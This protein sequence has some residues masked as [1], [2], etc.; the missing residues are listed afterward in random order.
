MAD[1]ELRGV[2]KAYGAIEVIKGVDLSIKHG[3]FCVFVGPS[4]CGKST[5]LRMISGLESISDGEVLIEGEVV[6]K[7]AP[8]DRGLAMVFQSYA[9][10][11]H[12]TVRQNLTFG[13]ENLNTP[14]SE[15]AAKVENVAKML[16]I[17]PLLAR[18]PKDLSGGQRQRVAI[19][20]A[21][22]REPRVFLFDEPLSNLD[23]ELRVEMRGEIS[24]LHRRLG[25]T[26]IYVTH[27]QVEAMTMA[28]KIAV[29][30]DG[31]V[32]QYGA[33]LD[34]Y[35]AP[36][37]LFVAGFIGSPRMN[38][39]AGR[40]EGGA[41]V[42]ASGPRVDLPANR[43]ALRQGAEV[44]IGI[45]PNGLQLADTG[46]ALS[47]TGVERTRWRKLPL[48]H[49]EGRRCSDRPCNRANPDRNGCRSAPLNQQQR[50]T[51]VRNRHDAQPAHGGLGMRQTWR[52]FGPKDTVRVEEMLQA[53]VE[54]VVSALHH[55]PPGQEWTLAEIRTRQAEI[56]RRSDGSPSG[57]SWE[58]VE[59]VP[60][61]EVIKTKGPGY[62]DHI[63]AYRASIRNLAACGISVLCYNFMPVLDWTRTV[64]RWPLPNGGTAMMFDLVDFA[65]FDLFI[66]RRAGAAADYGD[67]LTETATARF[68]G[69]SDA[70][71]QQLQQNVVA[72]LPGANDSW[73]VE[74]I[75]EML[76]I[77]APISRDQLAANLIDFLAEVVPTA[78]EVGMRLCCHPDDPP[79]PLLGLP[80][81]MSS[82]ADYAKVL[83]A[84]DSPAS[85]VTFCTGS[86]GV[87]AGFDAVGFVERLGAHIHFVHLRNTRRIAPASGAR[88]SFHE[89]EHLAGDTDIVGVIRV[90]LAEERKR[91]AAGR[92]DWQLPFRPD[93]GQD[94]MDD[95]KRASMPG[96]PLIGRMR[97]LA[98][99]RGVIAAFERADASH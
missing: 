53:G 72:G 86:L 46:L 92:V 21:V 58:V 89:S 83:A 51:C 2:T 76:A 14:K 91:K 79:F 13:L 11:P 74:Q 33:P 17:E 69:M 20:R 98:E 37:N 73:T 42:L 25:N 85:G 68:S 10:Y 4:G 63:A 36:D 3:E 8:A 50:G 15:I 23:A 75:R 60:V 95:L 93:H 70:T 24:R 19:G 59:S 6:N 44:T 62:A 41:V 77:Y 35:N 7:L 5:L 40:V 29:L 87:A 43:F 61:S 32:E 65:A 64:L 57:L 66:L 49:D 99:L 56:A 84:V 22:V 34:L 30:R 54:G 28:D 38:F 47:V 27:D 71:K 48:W 39:F 12:M 45:R 82:E 52:W 88:S 96:Y 16:Q 90:L 9:L 31:R 67:K 55:L 81:V 94:L 1:L 97:G 78:E 18:R 80:R 26:M